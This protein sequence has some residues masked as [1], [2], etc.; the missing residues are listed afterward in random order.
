MTA[1][2]VLRTV[3]PGSAADCAGLRK[4]DVLRRLNG[5]PVASFAD[6]QYA[7]HR[8]P[9][10][11]SVAVSWW[12]GGVEKSATLELAEGW[13]RTNSTWRPSLLDI[14]PS[15]PLYGTE[16]TAAEK[17]ALGLPPKRLAFRQQKLNAEEL[18]GRRG[19]GRTTSLSALRGSPWK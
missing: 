6:V 15:L 9:S 2:A 3:Q 16:L 14:L 18:R 11:G 12:R 1:T 17:K 7:L 8:A 5:L 10:K 13:R 19:C 4:G